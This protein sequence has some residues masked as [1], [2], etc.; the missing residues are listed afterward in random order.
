[1]KT[2][3]RA[4]ASVG[5]PDPATLRLS[6]TAHQPEKIRIGLQRLGQALTDH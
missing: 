4:A 1:M 5:P 2:R 3:P 6:F